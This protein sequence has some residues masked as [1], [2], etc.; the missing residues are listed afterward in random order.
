[1][2]GLLFF[3]PALIVLPIWTLYKIFWRRRWTPRNWLMLPLVAL[4]FIIALVVPNPGN[5]PQ[6]SPL[7]ARFFVAFWL[8]PMTMFPWQL[9]AW[10]RAGRRRR[11]TWWL[12]ITGA[13]TL[14]VGTVIYTIHWRMTPRDEYWVYNARSSYPFLLGL[15]T[16][17]RNHQA[18]TARVGREIHETPSEWHREYEIAY[19]K[20]NLLQVAGRMPG[21]T[22]IRRNGGNF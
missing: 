8:L 4:L 12:G 16:A 5:T 19:V 22:A 21:C 15:L 18:I 1:M 6:I 17:V 3:L 20:A 13:I 2:L 11:L 7:W 14:L 10:F 9:V